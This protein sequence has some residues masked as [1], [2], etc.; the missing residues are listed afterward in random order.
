MPR[1]RKG[2][3]RPADVNA[4]AVMIA[5]IATGEI[6]DAPE[7]DGKDPAA[8]AL[9]KKGGAARATRPPRPYQINPR[10]ARLVVRSRPAT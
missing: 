7:D 6:D 3:K 10:R 9:G 2:E 4:R 5:K 8:K 1:G